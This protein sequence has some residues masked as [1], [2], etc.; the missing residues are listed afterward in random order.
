MGLLL[1]G[2]GSQAAERRWGNHWPWRVPPF[3][4]ERS[5]AYMRQSSALVRVIGSLRVDW[6][7]VFAVVAGLL[8]GGLSLL[9][10]YSKT[11][12]AV[13]PTGFTDEL[14]TKVGSPT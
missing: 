10:L 11:A 14:L 4:R 2:A 6:R 3:R 12:S 9:F 1:R 5:G 7:I 13:T 8:A